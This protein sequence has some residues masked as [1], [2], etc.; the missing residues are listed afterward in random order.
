MRLFTYKEYLQVFLLLL[1]TLSII[2]GIF[3]VS[4]ITAEIILMLFIPSFAYIIIIE[5]R[6]R[7]VYNIRRLKIE[8]IK[9]KIHER[10]KFYKNHEIYLYVS[11]ELY[12]LIIH[13][14]IKFDENITVFAYPPYLSESN[15]LKYFIEVKELTIDKLN[16]IEDLYDL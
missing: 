14:N 7:K 4:V 9:N 8:E 15:S 6:L 3:N 12:Y 13:H 10:F 1:S 16:T 5:Y 11:F 2:M